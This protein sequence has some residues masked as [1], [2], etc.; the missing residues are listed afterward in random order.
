MT[1]STRARRRKRMSP[2]RFALHALAAVAL[3]LLAT[4]AVPARAAAELVVLV[5]G[6][7]MKVDGFA[8]DGDDAVLAF[9]SGGH[10]LLPMLRVERVLDDEVV[11]E[12]ETAALDGAAPFPVRWSDGLPRPSTAYGEL[13]WEAARRHALNPGLV[14][15]V[16]RAESAFDPRAISRKGARGLMQLMP[17][18]GERYG[19][20]PA[21]L[22]DP[23]K[24]VD[25]GVRYLRFLADRFDDDLARILAG[26]NA[27]EGTVDRFDGVPPYRETRGYVERIYAELGLG[28]APGL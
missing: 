24:N 1:D 12:P 7:V 28:G 21:E 19:L 16:I 25:A 2:S 9:T 26:Y 27:G 15:A 6:S 23:A 4:L 22:F 10:L 20:R 11:P 18:T 14:A 13:I 3:G 17:A 8:A 5:D